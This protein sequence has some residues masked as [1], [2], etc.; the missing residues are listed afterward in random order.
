MKSDL[1]KNTHLIIIRCMWKRESW[2]SFLS[3]YLFY[4]LQLLF[5]L[6]LVLHAT[7][8]RKQSFKPYQP[9]SDNALVV[10]WMV[11]LPVAIQYAWLHEA[12]EHVSPPPPPPKDN[13]IQILMVPTQRMCR[14]QTHTIRD[15][16]EIGHNV[17]VSQSFCRVL[18]KEEGTVW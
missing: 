5:L 12:V 15:K 7:N 13:Q 17:A 18:G 8:T 3:V 1:T 14:G 16:S 6:L 9:W 4:Y 11:L 2:A 10:D